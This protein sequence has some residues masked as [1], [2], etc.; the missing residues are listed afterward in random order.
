MSN[1]YWGR[2]TDPNQTPSGDGSGQPDQDATRQA[3]QP[4]EQPVYGEQP[5]GQQ[6][7]DSQSSDSQSNANSYGQSSYGQ[8]SAEAPQTGGYGQQAGGYGQSS[9][10]QT[11][12]DA[13]QTGGYGQSSYGQD[14]SAQSGYGQ[15][16]Y[17][18]ASADAPQT[19]AYVATGGY[20]QSS[21]DAPQVGGYGQSGYGQTSADAPQAGAYGATGG[22]GQSSADAPQA[23]GYGQ[24]GYGQTSADA[25]QAGAYGATGGYGAAGGYDQSQGYGQ[26]GYGDPTATA[27]GTQGGYGQTQDQFGYGQPSYGGQLYGPVSPMGAP[28]ASWGKRA[29]GGLID[30]VAPSI[31]VG[32]IVSIINS[33]VGYGETTTIGN[34]V[35]SVLMLGWYGYNQVFLGG[36]TGQ[37]FGRKIAKTRLVSEATGQPV[38][39]GMAL[40]RHI[41]HFLD[42]LICMV[43]W[44]FPLWDAKRQTLAD[45]VT[46]TIVIDESMG[47]GAPAGGYQPQ[48]YGY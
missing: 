3:S 37:T 16:S 19:G 24:S 36:T 33:A 22:Y 6:P 12:A 9:Y 39:I 26:S 25:P 45:K 38:G 47:G 32:I 30:W 42:S 48:Q 1:D 23:G 13:P 35:Q 11:S 44:L 7:N 14:S 28:Y 41:A 4:S 10:G 21:A 31:V 17:G 18:Q 8:P 27:Y 5:Y 2:P 34:L 40:L 15:S 46:S 20:G 43:G 29:L